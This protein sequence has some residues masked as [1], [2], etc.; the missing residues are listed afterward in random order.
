MEAIK[1]FLKGLESEKLNISGIGISMPGR[2]NP[3]NGKSLNY[4]N[5]IDE[6][7]NDLLQDE[8]DIPVFH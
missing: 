2:L 4:F 6:P 1:Q 8:L 7:L 3:K 5:F